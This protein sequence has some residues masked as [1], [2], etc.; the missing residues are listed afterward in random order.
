LILITDGEDHES[1]PLNEVKEAKND[2]IMIFTVGIGSL[3]GVPIPVL[4]SGTERGFKKDREGEVVISKLDELTLEK[5]ALETGGKYYRA[6]PGE[7]EL[8]KIYEAISGMDKKELASL[9]FTQ[10][11][12]RF[13]YA[14][15]FA[16]FFI[17]MEML[18]SERIAVK[19]EWRGRFR[20]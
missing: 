15:I 11:E 9:Q 4:E 3:Q 18:L 8:G 13:Q 2:G 10:F 16:L 6:T 1:D 5:I 14:L 12:E 20:G 17:I 7:V 19:K